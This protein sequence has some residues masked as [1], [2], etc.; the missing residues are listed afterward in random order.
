MAGSFF[1]VVLLCLINITPIIVLEYYVTITL[2]SISFAVFFITVLFFDYF[3]KADTLSSLNSSNASFFDVIPFAANIINLEGEILYANKI[4]K[5]TITKNPI[6]EKCYNLYS[7]DKSH[8]SNCPLGI[9]NKNEIDSYITIITSDLLNDRTFRILHRSIEYQGES[10]ILQVLEDL[11]DRQEELKLINK[12]LEK[13]VQMANYMA[14]KAEVAN[15]AKSEFL[16]TMSHEIRTPMNGIMGMTDFLL[17]SQLNPEQHKYTQIVKNSAKSLLTLINDI[18][19]FSKIE[20]GKLDLDSLDFDLKELVDEVI[21]VVEYFADKK[22]IDL[23]LDIDQSIHT[24]LIG[25][26]TRIKQIMINLIN[27][28]IKFTSEG[29]VEIKIVIEEDRE[30]QVIIKFYVVDSG[31]GISAENQSKLFKPFAQADSSTTRKYGGTGLGLVISKKLCELMGGEIGVDSEVGKGATF[32]FT[33]NL[34]KQQN[35]NSEK[36]DL[37]KN[38]SDEFELDFKNIKIEEMLILIAEDNV[39]NQMVIAKMISSMGGEKIDVVENGLQAVQEYGKKDYGLILMDC[40]MPEMSGFDA[41]REI[42]KIEMSSKKHVP[43]IALTA[44]AMKG[45]REKCIDAGMDDYI[46][47][48]IDKRQLKYSIY[49]MCKEMKLG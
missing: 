2:L 10:A 39:V 5:D 41:T 25:D 49:K 9:K 22:K 38:R 12:E 43:I 4:F 40:Q 21:D 44:N 23:V 35:I 45:D 3:F 33:L 47:K 19:D 8:C 27:N 1:I 17:E 26:S 14:Q 37:K 42:R 32:W 29:K 20:A 16:A 30:K 13:A 15:K 24:A 28:A 11:T 6:G 31:I 48:P 46:S 34:L 18:L 7:S 36:N